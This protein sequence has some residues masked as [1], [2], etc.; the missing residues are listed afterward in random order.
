MLGFIKKIFI[1]LLTSIVNASNHSK[2]VSSNNQHCMTQPTLINLRPNEYS[3]VL[4]YYPF[5]VHLDRRVRSFNTL[6]DPIVNDLIKYVF[7]MK[8]KI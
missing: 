8:Q 3:Q 6:N 2:C 4:C 1:R 7:Q 5:A